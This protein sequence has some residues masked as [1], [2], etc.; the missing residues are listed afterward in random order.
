MK[1]YIR[2]GLLAAML[3]VGVSAFAAQFNIGIRIGPPPAPRV[4]R[5]VPPSPGPG[6]VRIEGY[7]YPV[8][9][10]YRW[11]AAYW[12][13]AP[14][15]GALWVAPHHDGS[16]YFAGYWNGDRGQQGHDHASDRNRDRDY[17]R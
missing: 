7:W 9:G 1:N 15:A 10:K 3:L 4:V 17:R 14:Y 12:T 8:A 2:T 16:Q 11:H 13:Q 5:V 6:Y